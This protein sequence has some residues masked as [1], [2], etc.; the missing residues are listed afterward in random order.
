MKKLA[1]SELEGIV[2]KTD[3]KRNIQSAAFRVETADGSTP[4]C[5]ATSSTSAR[6]NPN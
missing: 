3:S 6:G 4:A 1:E 5:P 2:A